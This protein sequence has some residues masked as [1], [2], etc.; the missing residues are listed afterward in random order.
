MKNPLRD[1]K[2]FKERDPILVGA[3]TALIMVLIGSATFFADDLPIIGGG[4]EYAAEFSEA[5]GLKTR[6]EVRVAGVKVGE[7]SAVDLKGDHVEVR[8]KVKGVWLGDRTSAA[9]KIKTLLGQKNLLLDPRGGNEMDPST[10]IPKDRTTSPYDVTEVFNDLANTAGSI[11][12]VKLA[13]SFRTLSETMGASAPQD[14]RAALDGMSALSKTLASRDDELTKLFDGTS[15]VSKLLGD[16]SA[17]VESLINNGNVLLTELNARKDA[18]AKLF[19]GTKALGQQLRGLV[20]DN[21]KTLG[22][23]LDQLDRV[24]AVL[25][26]NQDKLTESLRLA[27]PYYRLLGNAV[28][29]G[30]WIDTYICGLVQAGGDCAP[31]GGS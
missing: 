25:Q 27:G 16:R 3:V 21:E 31:K 2:P 22:P 4:T 9:I 23:A 6:D 18:I 28:G 24:G 26:R 30:R 7:I 29:N 8:F 5:A 1:L 11:D 12:T 15:K 10:P 14:V 13:Q 19:G 20:A 17:Q